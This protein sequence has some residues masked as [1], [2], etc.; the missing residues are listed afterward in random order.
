MAAVARKFPP[1]STRLACPQPANRAPAVAAI[2]INLIRLFPGTSFRRGPFSNLHAFAQGLPA[3]DSI[4]AGEA[5]SFDGQT[6]RAE[7]TH[8]PHRGPSRA[9]FRT[10]HPRK[11]EN[12]QSQALDFEHLSSNHL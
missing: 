3:W 4:T 6:R 1:W 11:T 10:A 12:S 2:L 9:A 5:V 7:M 8:K